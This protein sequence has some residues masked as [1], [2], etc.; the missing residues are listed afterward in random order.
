MTLISRLVLVDT[1]Q[2]VRLGLNFDHPTLRAFSTLCQHDLLTSYSTTVVQ[3]EIARHIDSAMDEALS[4]LKLFRRRARMLETLADEALE[5]LFREIPDDEVR[6]KAH[7]VYEQF[8][9]ETKTNVLAINDV[10]PENVFEMYF[11]GRPPFGSG[12][13]K[14]E[15][16]DAFSV[17]AFH[18]ALEGQPAYI[19]SG[20]TDIV[21][22]CDAFPPLCAVESLEKLLDI[23]NA[24]Q[25]VITNLVKAAFLDLQDYIEASIDQIIKDAGAYNDGAWDDSEVEDLSVSRIHDIDPSVVR[26]DE[27][28]CTIMFDV[29]I[30]IEFIVEGPDYLNGTYDSEDGRIFSHRTVSISSAESQTFSVEVNLRYKL[31]DGRLL[32]IEPDVHVLGIS[33]GVAVNVDEGDDPW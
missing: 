14:S 6:R 21:A 22:M 8:V 9:V 1:E 16:P 31:Q 25:N 10:L 28:G 2:F 24:H 33:D 32:D 3:R 4:A 30:D 18:S 23:Y 17:L 11:G 5:A 13:K 27:H 19:V 15:F 26:V 12:K 20:D 29:D 7:A